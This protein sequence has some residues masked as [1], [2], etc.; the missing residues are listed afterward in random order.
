MYCANGE[1]YVGLKDGIEYV[2]RFGNTAKTSE[3][4]EEGKLNRYL[5]VTARVDDAHFPPPQLEPEPQDVPAPDSSKPADEPKKACDDPPVTKAGPDEA[6][7]KDENKDDA[8]QPKAKQPDKTSDVDRI[9]KEN[10]R[11]RNEARDKKKK[12][13]DK[14]A[15]LNARFADWYYV[16]SEDTYKKIHLGRAD[17]IRERKGG[18]DEGY[19]P[20]VFRKLQKDGLTTGKPD[21]LDHDPHGDGPP[22]FPP[23]PGRRP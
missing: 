22:G 16:I 8:K 11:R 3:G 7:D 19:G 23:L 14:V 5:F 13:A 18:K 10:D 2:L 20:D 12:A 15:E 6:Q 17:I 1:V 4:S 21:D 9:K